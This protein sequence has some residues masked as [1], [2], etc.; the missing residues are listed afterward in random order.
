[1]TSSRRQAG[2]LLNPPAEILG[3]QNAV[4][5]GR[6]TRYYV[7]DF[8]GCLSVKS[9]ISGSAVWKIPG[10]RFEVHENT[11]LILNDRQ[12][13]SMTI[14]SARKVN[15]FCIFFERGFVEDVFRSKVS[16]ALTLLDDPEASPP[17]SVGF[18]E[19]IE[20]QRGPVRRELQRF[21]ERLAAGRLS[22]QDSTV[23]LYRLA[24]RLLA[25]HRQ[26]ELLASRLPAIRSATRE[27]LFR[28][29]LRG[30]DCLLSS[31]SNPVSLR[32]AARAACLSPF[33]FHRSF[34]AV[35]AE[36][37]HK[38]ATRHRLERARHLLRETGRSVT[39]ICLEAGFESL[40]S[41]S[42]LFSRTYGASPRDYRRAKISKI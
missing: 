8:E 37:P 14:D 30:R 3:K 11:Y 5:S 22:T 2:V 39:E 42:T 13:Y 31:L 16:P 20:P 10:R 6:G 18:V 17:Q 34:Q 33:H 29:V 40:S 24:E 15:T 28:R 26:T 36:T 35:F 21:K 7:P 12:H 19:C 23:D 25:E 38:H 41:F 9:M 1:M 4:L 27:E 32:D